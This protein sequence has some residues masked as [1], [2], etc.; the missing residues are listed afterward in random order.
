MT[1][2]FLRTALRRVIAACEGAQRDTVAAAIYITTLDT[3][4]NIFTF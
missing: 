2:S 4:S 3:I 1:P